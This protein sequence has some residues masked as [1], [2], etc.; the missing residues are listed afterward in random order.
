V[1]R[2]P[3]DLM[4]QAGE[5]RDAVLG[6]TTSQLESARQD[7]VNTGVAWQGRH[8]M[9]R[10]WE[11]T[12]A[13]GPARLTP[14]SQYEQRGVSPEDYSLAMAMRMANV[15]P[16]AQRQSPAEIGRNVMGRLANYF[17]RDVERVTENRVAMSR[18]LSGNGDS[19]QGAGGAL[20]GAMAEA[21][22]GM[23]GAAMS[24]MSEAQRRM[25]H[26]GLDT[27]GVGYISRVGTEAVTVTTDGARPV[28]E[29]DRRNAAATMRDVEY[30]TYGGR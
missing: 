8:L 29:R 27:S 30:E 4:R 20:R 26:L 22:A 12:S 1:P 19:P 18:A 21:A 25:G 13:G 6:Y 17:Q 3:L 28:T 11:R 9:E 23:G 14:Y 24:N 15:R 2:S 10:D 16:E 7:R 5:R